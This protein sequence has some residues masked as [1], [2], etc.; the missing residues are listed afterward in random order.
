VFELDQ[1]ED[2]FGD[3]ADLAGAEHHPLQAR[4]RW[5]SSAKPRSPW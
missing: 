3:V 4:H 1:D 2:S 5:D